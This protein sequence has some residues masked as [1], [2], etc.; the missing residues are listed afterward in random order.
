M[1]IGRGVIPHDLAHFAT[2]AHFGLEH[3]FWGLLARGATFTRGTDRRRTRPGRALV[4]QHR[5]ELHDA[6]QLGNVHHSMWTNGDPTPVGPT[7]ERLSERWKALP[8]KGTLTVE[9]PAK[10]APGSRIGRR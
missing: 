10:P 8:S 3:G 1:P 5:R 6:E 7:F 2:E 4:I 9:W